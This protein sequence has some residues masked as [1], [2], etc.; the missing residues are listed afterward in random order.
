VLGRLDARTHAVRVRPG[1][2]DLLPRV[3]EA[4]RTGSLFGGAPV[5]VV[6]DADALREEQQHGLLALLPEG[7]G[8]HLVLVGT[9]PDMRRRLYATCQRNGGAFEFRRLPPPR[10]AAWLR[11]EAAARGHVLTADAGELLVDLVGPDLRV[12]AN[13]IEKLSLY[14][15]AGKPIDVDA[16]SAVVGSLRARSMLELADTLQRR[17]LGPAV[18]LIRQLVT[19]GSQPIAIVAFVAG[20]IR[21]LLVTASL[22]RAGLSADDIGRRLGVS[23]WV[24]ERLSEGARRYDARTLRTALLGIGAV[25][26]TLKSS[27]VPPERLLER[28][29]LSLGRVDGRA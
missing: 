29:V 8:A 26:V 3:E 2:D 6:L 20:Q 18:A 24:A 22:R 11:E 7:D 23:S 5:A 1:D 4:L 10:V 12:G 13:E 14:V 25:D 28:W 9:A 16:V 21:R 19:Q 27:R 17:N 15:T